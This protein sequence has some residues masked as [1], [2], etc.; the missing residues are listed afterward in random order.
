MAGPRAVPYG[1]PVEPFDRQHPVRG[2]FS[3]PRDG[4]WTLSRLSVG[5]VLAPADGLR[6]GYGEPLVETRART[7]PLVVVGHGNSSRF[8]SRAR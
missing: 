4:E 8:L 2:Y 1:W 6:I 5:N 7:L 3:D